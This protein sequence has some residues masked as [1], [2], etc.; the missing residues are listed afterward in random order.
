MVTGRF[1]LSLLLVHAG[2]Q[3]DSAVMANEKEQISCNSEA[4]VNVTKKQF[5]IKVRGLK[6]LLILQA[7]LGV[8]E[9]ISSLWPV[10]VACW[11]ANPPM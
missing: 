6:A 7:A 4:G 1:F 5:M 11:S 3:Q 9:C 10:L 2:F 8:L